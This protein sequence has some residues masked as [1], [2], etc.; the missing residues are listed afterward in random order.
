MKRNI[1]LSILGICAAL[2]ATAQPEAVFNQIVKQYTWN[3]DGSM[4]FR[5][6]KELKLNTHLSFNSLYGET[7]IVYNPEFQ[8]L[9]INES[10][11]KQADGTIIRTPD[12]AFNEVLPAFATDAP[13]YNHL[14]EMVVTH[15]GL[16]IGAT[17]H[18]DYTLTTNVGFYP[19]LD[20]AESLQEHA[21]IE[22][23]QIDITLPEDEELTYGMNALKSEPTHRTEH[24]MKTYS[25]HW[26][27]IP[28][29][30]ME[31]HIAGETFPMLFAS[32]A[33][34]ENGVA[35]LSAMKIEP[36]ACASVVS[37]LLNNDRTPPEEKRAEIQRYVLQNIATCNL[38]IH[39][40]AQIRKPSEVL[41]SAYGSPAEKAALLASM[42]LAA[43]LDAEIMI[44]FPAY[45]S[46]IAVNSVSDIRIKSG[47]HYF[48]PIQKD[49]PDP[50]LQAA[51][52]Q[53]WQ[54]SESGVSLITL[55]EKQMKLDYK[56]QISIND[57]IARENGTLTNSEEKT[58][59]PDFDSKKPLRSETGYTVYTLPAPAKGID[60]WKLKLNSRRTQS[61]ELNC[62]IKET[63]HYTVSTDGWEMKTQPFRKE[64]NNAVGK[65]SLT[66]QQQG[67][68]FV[69]HREIE[70]LKPIIRPDEY[71]DFRTLMLLWEND[72]YRTLILKK[73]NSSME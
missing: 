21:P 16:E 10:Y 34:G 46:P 40:S 20:V 56:V 19:F 3:R 17:I 2:T 47:E 36:E 55:T 48:S 22:K 8:T 38:P 28:A 23:Y 18:L 42:F 62:K 13:A 63:C 11:T 71:N 50:A 37:T 31:S 61:M 9:K 70:L 4:T 15:T 66:M 14:R 58:A 43:G 27:N 52:H 65:A 24:G 59:K 6:R 49:A 67:E 53:F 57:T 39:L 7:F 25:W 72:A 29:I 32:N 33:G 30:S 26:E 1:L 64:I 54:T 69:I 73:T 51:R 60:S 12:N 45:A 35:W 41:Q 5:Y 68:Q 44:A